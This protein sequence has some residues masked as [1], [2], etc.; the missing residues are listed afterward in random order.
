MVSGGYILGATA[1]VQP[2]TLIISLERISVRLLGVGSVGNN[3]YRVTSYQRN[4]LSN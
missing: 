2:K 1:L 3:R 4:R